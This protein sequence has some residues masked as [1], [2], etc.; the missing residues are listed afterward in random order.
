MVALS[1]EG[2]IPLW[3][4]VN[5]VAQCGL[6]P[7]MGSGQ[8]IILYIIQAYLIVGVGTMFFEA[9]YILH[10]PFTKSLRLPGPI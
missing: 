10:T 6:S 9:F 7:L 5:L 4:S 2:L 3:N 8:I 1:L